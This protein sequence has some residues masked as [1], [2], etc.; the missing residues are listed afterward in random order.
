MTEEDRTKLE[1]Y[2]AS[3]EGRA[4][5]AI[6]ALEM[7]VDDLTDAAKH[8]DGAIVIRNDMQRIRNARNKLMDLEIDVTPIFSVA[9]E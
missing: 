4:D 9:A 7:V 1:K 8:R 3:H 2:Q 6:M 5:I